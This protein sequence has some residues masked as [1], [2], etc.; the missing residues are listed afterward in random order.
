LQTLRDEKIAWKAL[1]QETPEDVGRRV[2]AEELDLPDAEL[3]APAY[4]S[5]SM[6]QVRTIRQTLLDPHGAVLVL[7]GT[8]PVQETLLAIDGFFGTWR[9]PREPARQPQPPAPPRKRRLVLVPWPGLDQ[10][11]VVLGK[12]LPPLAVRDEV[13]LQTALGR[14]LGGLNSFRTDSGTS[15]GPRGRVRL[16]R[17]GGVL[18]VL[19]TV[20]ARVTRPAL[21]DSLG[22][23][24][25]LAVLPEK[26][27]SSLSREIASQ[28]GSA[29]GTGSAGHVAAAADLFLRGQERDRQAQK[30]RALATL[31]PREVQAAIAQHLDEATTS[32]V[33]VGDG[34]V[35]RAAAKALAMTLEVHPRPG[36]KD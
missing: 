23:L 28:Q 17:T 32:V 15:Y 19:L 7:A 12:R 27:W 11:H 4:G 26:T 21:R 24:R 16:D 2:L 13:A 34:E 3:D 10:T 33:I 35:V 25:E 9:P 18:E 29:S 22:G 1:A 8:F 14:Y 30:A 5:V 36:A 6:A 20:D 31:R